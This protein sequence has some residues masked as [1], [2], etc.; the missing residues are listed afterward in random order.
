[1]ST[2]VN[3]Y[4][5]KKKAEVKKAPP[6][7]VPAS[8]SQK[9]VNKS[10]TIQ[11]AAAASRKVVVTPSIS[12]TS[13]KK[14]P[15]PQAPLKAVPLPSSSSSSS[16]FKP[17]VT[18]KKTLIKKKNS[19]KQQLKQEIALLKKRKTLQKLQKEAEKRHLQQQ[20]EKEAK[21]KQLEEM[22]KERQR[23]KEEKQRQKMEVL[24]EKEEERLKKQQE[25]QKKLQEKH[26]KEQERTEREQ[27]AYQRYELERHHQTFQRYLQQL[28]QMQNGGMYNGITLPT[29]LDHPRL[30]VPQRVMSQ[31]ALTAA[32]PLSTSMLPNPL[33]PPPPAAAALVPQPVAPTTA[34]VALPQQMPAKNAPPQATAPSAGVD[35]PVVIPPTTKTEYTTTTAAAAC[36]SPA[37]PAQTFIVASTEVRA[38]ISSTDKPPATSAI[39]VE[40]PNAQPQPVAVAVPSQPQQTTNT[41]TVAP[42]TTAAFPSKNAVDPVPSKNA[43]AATFARLQNGVPSLV[44]PPPPNAVPLIMTSLGRPLAP[45]ILPHTRGLMMLPQNAMHCGLPFATGTIPRALVPGLAYHPSHFMAQP[46]GF[47]RPV[48]PPTMLWQQRPPPRPLPPRPKPIKPTLLGA[49]MKAPSPFAHYQ[50]L[51]I[52]LVRPTEEKS[53]GVNLKLYHQSTLVDPE[54]LEQEQAVVM[55]AAIQHKPSF[56]SNLPTT[57]A[58]SNKSEAAITSTVSLVKDST[59]TTAFGWNLPTTNTASNKSEAAITLMVSLEK[60]STKTTPEEPKQAGEKMVVTQVSSEAMATNESFHA[61]EERKPVVV[62]E[63]GRVDAATDLEISE[64]LNPQEA[65]NSGSS[66]NNTETAKS[67]IHVATNTTVA[68]K[69]GPEIIE[70]PPQTKTIAGPI[71]ATAETQKDTTMANTTTLGDSTAKSDLNVATQPSVTSSHTTYEVPSSDTTTAKSINPVSRATENTTMKEANA[72]KPR[73]RRRRRV[74]YSF[75]LVVDA[76]KQNKFREKADSGNRGELLQPGDIIVS[77]GGTPIAGMAFAQACATFGTKAE[78]VDETTICAR[79]VVARK[80]KPIFPSVKSLSSKALPKQ[81]PATI[82]PQPVFS[83]P[84]ALPTATNSSEFQVAELAVLA[85]CII[86]AIHQSSRLLGQS[87]ATGTVFDPMTTLFRQIGTLKHFKYDGDSLPVRSVPTLHSK[88]IEIARGIESDF[89][90]KHLANWTKAIEKEGG[91]A[92]VTFASDAERSALRQLP[93]PVK[94]CRCKRNDHEYLHDPKCLL[95]RDMSRLVPKDLLSGLLRTDEKVSKKKDAGMNAVEKGFKDRIVRL[96]KTAGME[97]AEARFVAQME[98]VQV[99]ECKKAVF[100]PTSL[101]AMIL[102]TLFE[103]QREFPVSHVARDDTDD[104]E[105]DDDEEEEEDVPLAMMLEGKRK[106]PASAEQPNSKRQKQMPAAEKMISFRY[107]LRMLQHISKVWGHVYREPS[108]ED[109]AW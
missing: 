18:P 35:Q 74:N 39:A 37:L 83:T 99:K 89:R 56:G 45:N 108:H 55:I 80:P 44:P 69:V 73:K 51:E 14:R 70:K 67:V 13:I 41:T 57:N 72:N 26:I 104:E 59:K 19:T 94:G 52:D 6:H 30:V 79:L 38:A 31:N 60:D 27:L 42:T 105:E 40:P 22:Q 78:K 36:S 8:S 25:R 84:R 21:L 20:K 62:K 1:M 17:I 47:Y 109:Y 85:D 29:A 23:I 82:K 98:E 66:A 102:S 50:L 76:A 107:L 4:A 106:A 61:A 32:A 2:I 90:N 96:K 71:P 24:K 64:P 15:P 9:N 53:F 103:L 88:W 87:L 97:E 95:Y 91:A 101:A 7:S 81:T 11:H 16:S 75:M 33:A 49:P 3:P 63:E 93:R 54:W 34:L 100:A 28:Q 77:I 58:A 43:A 68:K 48:P 5:K 12:T 46:A 65:S 92:D 10:D 86:R